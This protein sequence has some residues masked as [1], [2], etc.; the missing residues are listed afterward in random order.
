[1]RSMRKSGKAQLFHIF[2]LSLVFISDG[3][4]QGLIDFRNK[5]H[6]YIDAP[7]LDCD[8]TSRLTATNIVAELYWAHVGSTNFAI[9]KAEGGGT[10]APAPLRTATNLL[11]YWKRDFDRQ[12][13]VPPGTVVQLMV[14]A[15]DA[16]AGGF[17]EAKKSGKKWGESAV[18]S[19]K[20]G[21]PG[22]R[23]VPGVM[24]APPAPAAMVG[25]KSFRVGPCP[26]TRPK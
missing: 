22:G 15:W 14:R 9:A 13:G 5:I 25:L 19:V 12:V 24:P 1:M 4:A 20:A 26:G 3:F 8:G 23:A 18:F 7:L 11:G 10:A 2:A 17:V 6:G 21:D 16:S